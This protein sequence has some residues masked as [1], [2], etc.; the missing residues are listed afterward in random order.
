MTVLSAHAVH[1]HFGRK[2]ALDGLSADFAIGQVTCIVGP[3]GAGKS[4]LLSVLAGLRNPDAGSIVLDS[5]H[6][7]TMAPRDRAK[8]LAFLP[9]IPEVAWAI[10]VRTLVAL[11]RT[12]YRGA[13]GLGATDEAAVDRAMELTGTTPLA[14]RNVATL[15]GGERARVLLARA[16]AGEPQ[17]LLADEPLAGLDPGYQLEVATLF[18]EMAH[19]QG[20]GV[21]VTLHDLHMAL[22]M[23]DRVLVLNG[24]RIIADDHPKQALSPEILKQAYG[25]ETRFWD[26]E[27]GPMIEIVGGRG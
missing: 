22:R 7:T 1:V 10:D 2:I 13:R 16:L 9:Q 14:Q 24:G 26:G 19:K 11:G 8:R 5:N 3:N 15:S 23:A 21:I 17:W 18:R 20:K 25:V 6:F 12:P 4:T 27:A